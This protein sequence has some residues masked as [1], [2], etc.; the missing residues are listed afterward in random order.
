MMQ[1]ARKALS[2]AG[3][4]AGVALIVM[5]IV[6]AG[7][8]Y[9]RNKYGSWKTPR[10]TLVTKYKALRNINGDGPLPELTT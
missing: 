1:K 2:Y 7:V 10:N 6:V 4:I 5:A 9:R 3:V 8:I